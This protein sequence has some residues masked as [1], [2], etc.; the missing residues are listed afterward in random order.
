MSLA[1][2]RLT[3][4]VRSPLMPGGEGRPG[5]PAP[6]DRMVL[7]IG[8]LPPVV[9]GP[10]TV[11]TTVPA[12]PPVVSAGS[13]IVTTIGPPS[14]PIP[15]RGSAMSLVIPRGFTFSQGWN[16]PVGQNAFGFSGQPTGPSPIGQPGMA[17]GGGVLGTIDNILDVINRVR[18]AFGAPAGGTGGPGPIAAPGGVDLSGLGG[19]GAGGL[20]GV[21]GAMGG[22]VARVATRYPRVRAVVSG[23]VGYY[24]FDKALGWM[25]KKGNPPKPRM[26]VL[27]PKALRRADRRVCGFATYARSALKQ[28]GYQVSSTRR[29]SSC[30]PKKKG[31]ITRK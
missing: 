18:G 2:N 17:S 4:R 5:D 20:G 24:I 7:P 13:G 28:Y 31:C 26:N 9:S 14:A 6:R 30:K 22:A 10:G 27:N 12:I 19:V 25:F 21:I 3:H 29:A 23:V 1:L 11:T 16:T 8:M 15:S